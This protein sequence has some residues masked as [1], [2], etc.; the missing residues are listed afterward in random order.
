MNNTLSRNVVDIFFICSGCGKIY[1]EG[2]HYRRLVEKRKGIIH[3]AQDD[4]ACSFYGVQKSSDENM[5]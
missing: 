2:M 4:A 1:W 5:P 3:D